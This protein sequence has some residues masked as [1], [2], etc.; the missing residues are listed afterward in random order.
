[1]LTLPQNLTALAQDTTLTP[2]DIVEIERISGKQKLLESRL[3]KDEE[4]RLELAKQYYN[5]A[6]EQPSREIYGKIWPPEAHIF[7]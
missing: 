2:E 1:M 5:P 4:R 7:C 3:L 6:N